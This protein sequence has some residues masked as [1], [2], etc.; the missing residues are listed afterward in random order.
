M[1]VQE[2]RD[3]DAELETRDIAALTECMIVLDELAPAPADA[4]GMY[5]V[6]T[7]S[8]ASYVVDY[9]LGACTCADHQYRDVTCKHQRR[10]EFETGVR[11]IPAWVDREKLDDGFRM[12]V[13]SDDDA[14]PDP[15]AGAG[16]AQGG[17]A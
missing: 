6:T 7:E 14:D 5:H 2:R 11:P 12:F 9:Q 4:P 10:V 1:S 8:G 17:V 15:D 13:N 3:A 16:A